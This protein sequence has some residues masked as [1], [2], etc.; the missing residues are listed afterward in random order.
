MWL[1]C[2]NFGAGLGC[3]CVPV[4]VLVWV[5]VS[6]GMGVGWLLRSGFPVCVSALRHLVASRFPGAGRGVLAASGW[7]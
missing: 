4:P 1:G 3:R 5:W 7:R 6:W 2:G